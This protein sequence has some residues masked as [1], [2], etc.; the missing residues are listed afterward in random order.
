V[1]PRLGKTISGHGSAYTYLPV[2]VDHFLT[3][4]ELTLR[5]RDRGFEVTQVRMLMFH[6]V[7]LHV[8][9]KPSR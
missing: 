5:L 3:P 2:S 9:V 6:T 1:V 8:A 7:A 4:R